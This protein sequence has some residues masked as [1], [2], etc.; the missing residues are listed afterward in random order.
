MIKVNAVPFKE[1]M[2][3]GWIVYATGN[4]YEY[5]FKFENKDDALIFVKDNQGIYKVSEN[6]LM[7]KITYEDPI[8]YIYIDDELC[9][10]RGEKYIAT[11]ETG[12]T[13]IISPEQLERHYVKK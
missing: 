13:S 1:G 6:D 7:F 11:D 5:D 10:I 2:E 9:E 12:V 3:D 4:F 8:P